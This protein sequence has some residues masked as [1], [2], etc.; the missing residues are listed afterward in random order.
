MDININK[1][2]DKLDGEIDATSA[3]IIEK[4]EER[5]TATPEEKTRLDKY[6]DVLNARLDAASA[7]RDALALALYAAP[8]PAPGKNTPLAFDVS[9]PPVYAEHTI[10]PPLLCV[11]PFSLKTL[12]KLVSVCVFLRGM[13]IYRAKMIVVYA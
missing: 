10:P 2:L 6:I 9:A 4:E 3:R 8:A 13:S 1:R 5:K 11:S 12:C 7:T